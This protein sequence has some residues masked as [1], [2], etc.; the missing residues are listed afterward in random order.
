MAA[1]GLDGVSQSRTFALDDDELDPG[2]AAA[3]D[4]EPKP[5]K[6]CNVCRLLLFTSGGD[7]AIEGG[8]D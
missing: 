2:D 3:D 6:L 5:K 1:V 4:D 8:R 7:V